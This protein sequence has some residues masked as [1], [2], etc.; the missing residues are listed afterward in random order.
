MLI[1][2][3]VVQMAPEARPRLRNG[4]LILEWEHIAE[5]IGTL[6]LTALAARYG[7]HYV[8]LTK[9]AAAM[10]GY[11]L[12]RDDEIKARAVQAWNTCPAFATGAGTAEAIEAGFAL[13]AAKERDDV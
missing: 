5:I 13:L 8:V 10:F 2:P 1:P 4:R 6:A 12:M 11:G 7:V 3:G 9:V